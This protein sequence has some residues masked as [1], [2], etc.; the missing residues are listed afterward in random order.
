M[1][2][3]VPSPHTAALNDILRASRTRS[4]ESVSGLDCFV[5]GETRSNIDRLTSH[6]RVLLLFVGASRDRGN[7]QVTNAQ[8]PVF[9]F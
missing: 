9:P 1:L 7:M 8:S 3:F 6:F 4:D 5:V 2:R